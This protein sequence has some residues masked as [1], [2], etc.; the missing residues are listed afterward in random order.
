MSSNVTV[1]AGDGQE[2]VIEVKVR[3]RINTNRTAKPTIQ[4]EVPLQ[5][6][7][8]THPRTKRRSMAEQDPPESDIDHYLAPPSWE[9]ATRRPSL[10]FNG[11][12]RTTYMDPPESDLDGYL[13][14]PET[15][16]RRNAQFARS[17]RRT[18]STTNR[19]SKRLSRASEA[20]AATAEFNGWGDPVQPF[21]RM[22]DIELEERPVTTR[23]SRMPDGTLKIDGPDGESK[24]PQPQYGM[25]FYLILFALSMTN[26]LVAFEG[27]VVSTALPTIVRELGGGSSYV[28]VSSGYFLASTVLQPLYGQLADIFGRRNLILFATVAFVVGS[29]ISGGAPDMSV[30]IL[31]RV[32]Q[33]VGTFYLSHDLVQELY[34][35]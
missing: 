35:D 2:F 6:D 17:L 4:E 22:D 7:V 25:N 20:F 11:R 8:S 18:E 15:G 31:G 29:G 19:M 1:D 9:Q 21:R 28:W 30:M 34:T 5:L 16:T 3:P 10:P 33:G 32:I 24:T 13:S 27:T 12:R 23:I 14:Q 26:I